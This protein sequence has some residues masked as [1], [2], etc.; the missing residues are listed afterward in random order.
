VLFV[1]FNV[2][3]VSITAMA[4]ANKKLMLGVIKGSPLE[5]IEEENQWGLA[6]PDLV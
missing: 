5:H 1:P 3:W 6:N 4:F 2:G